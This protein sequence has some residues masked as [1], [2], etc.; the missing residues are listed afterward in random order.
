MIIAKALLIVVAAILLLCAGVTVYTGILLIRRPPM[1]LYRMLIGQAGFLP[2]SRIPRRQIELLVAVEDPF[3]YTHHGFAL[4]G[5]R[6]AAEEN[7]RAR[8]IVQGG[9]TITQKLVKNLYFRFTRSYLRKVAEL[10]I[11]LVLE[12][13]LGKTRILEM[14]VNII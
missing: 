9:S 12:L 6:K 8:R 3:F 7:S 13:R 14:Y 10:L 1:A 2:L 11:A 5:I 4:E